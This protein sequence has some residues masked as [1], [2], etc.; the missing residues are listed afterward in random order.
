D[1]EEAPACARENRARR[2]ASPPAVGTMS[3]PSE[4]AATRDDGFCEADA[5]SGAGG[6]DAPQRTHPRRHPR[7]R[8]PAPHRAWRGRHHRRRILVADLRVTAYSETWLAVLARER[9]LLSAL[10]RGRVRI[11]GSRK[12]LVAFRKCSP[13]WAPSTT[14]P[15]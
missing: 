6:G 1:R 5:F 12:L 14:I 11:E 8:E 4:C 7:R 10:L 9:S 15:L 13:S 3:A 2:F